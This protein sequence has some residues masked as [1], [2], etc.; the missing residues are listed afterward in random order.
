[1]NGYEVIAK[2]LKKEGFQWMACFPANPLIEA[3]AKEGIQPITFRQERGAI[4]AADAYS[5]Y[6]A[7]KGKYGLFACQGGPGIENSFGGIAQAYADSVPIL[8]LPDSPGNYKSEVKPNFSGP[9][10]YQNITKWATSV[11]NV[12]DIPD[13]MRRAMISLKNGRPAPVMLE[14]HRDVMTDEVEKFE[15]QI[16]EKYTSVPN[17]LDLKKALQKILSAKKPVIWAGQ[18][19][20]YSGATEE[21]KNFCEI[22][23]VPVITTM[24]GKSA[25]N[26]NHYLS[27]GAAN[28]TA[29]KPV[30]DW[31]KESDVIFA[32]GASLT[33]TNYGIDLPKGKF[34]IHSTNNIEDISKEYDTNIGLLGDSK[35]TLKLLINLVKDMNFDQDSKVHDS[36]LDEIKQSKAEWMKEW[37]PILKTDMT[38]INPYRV[39]YEIN[40]NIDNE[41]SVVT[42]DAGHPRDEVMPFY[43]ATIPH[44][45]IG[46]GK[47]THL[48]YGIPL[49]IGAKIADPSRFC[50]NIMGDAAFGMSGLDIETSIRAGAPITTVVLNNGTMG[51]YNHTLPTAMEKYNT[52]N[53]TGNY[54]VIA[55]GLGAVGITV[56]SPDEIG[57][58]IK[59]A[60]KINF[61]DKKSV[62]IDIKTQQQMKF[63]IYS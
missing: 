52:A 9:L 1:M 6:M 5:R 33:V 43:N 58:A 14:M 47:T 56:N 51:G 15:Y 38:P 29:P 11:R 45:Y 40:K 46:W 18:G 31:I 50:V 39:V 7:S 42:H 13:L 63:S 4:M 17:T 32:I 60:R 61:E 62:L 26:E 57:I 55:E 24:P 20:L 8:F 12:N 16:T 53:M 35:E 36:L 19:I 27:L 48:G 59:K 49:M 10:N 44:S 22:I 41:T 25:I 2:I 21:L 54:S 30:W 28:R 23:N 37:L 34:L 3:V